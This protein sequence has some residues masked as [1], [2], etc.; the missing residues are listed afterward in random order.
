M[1]E[2][3]CTVQTC[4]YNKDYYCALKSITVGGSSAKKPEETSCDSFRERK[5]GS[6]SNA[7]GEAT[8]TSQ[9]DCKAIDCMYNNDCRC[10]AGK[11]NVEGNHACTAKETECATFARAK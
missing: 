5:E 8:A 6:Y 9:I 2:L 11:I 1:T 3:R 7:L 10:H 4:M